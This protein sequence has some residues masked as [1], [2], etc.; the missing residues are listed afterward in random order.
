M[1]AKEVQPSIKLRNAPFC[2]KQWM[3]AGNPSDFLNQLIADFG[4]YVHYRGLLNFYLINDPELVRQ[5][6]KETH[7]QFDKNTPIYNR[8]RNALGNS[9]VNAEGANWRRKRKLIQPSFSPASIKSFFNYMTESSNKLAAEWETYASAGNSFNVAKEMNKLTLEIAGK[10]FFSD[11]FSDVIRPIRKWT[12]VINKYSARLPIPILTHPYFPTPLNFQLKRVL[13]EYGNFITNMIQSR[14]THPDK[15]DLLSTFLK[16]RDENTGEP[17]KNKEIAE[18]VLGMIIGGH[19]T[20]STALTWIFYELSE[21]PAVE[22]QI[23]EEIRSVTED[24]PLK[25]EN[26]Q[27]LKY[28]KAVIHETMR[29]HPPLWFENRNVMQNVK[30]GDNMVPKGSMIILSRY[31]LHRNPKVW[32]N[33][34]QFE[35]TRFYPETPDTINEVKASGAYIPF[36]SGPRICI[37]RHFA[38][39]EIIVILC[40][41]LQKFRIRVSSKN[42]DA[43]ATNL[44]MEP[45]NGLLVQIEKQTHP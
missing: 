38:M 6:L 8:F 17:M 4:D 34:D 2:Y 33:A 32:K 39:M 36:S 5:V 42:R 15:D 3:L 23:I 43:I 10:S 11:G 9:L 31:A 19:E 45:R 35:P 14:I 26:I 29:L 20:S 16:L 21:N 37:G 44:T 25:F 27:E 18:E 30:L 13:K 22:I 7:R 40:T 12:Q 1:K 41:L 24:Q 28:T